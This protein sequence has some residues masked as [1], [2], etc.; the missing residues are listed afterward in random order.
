MKRVFTIA[1]CLLSQQIIKANALPADSTIKAKNVSSTSTRPAD[2]ALALVVKELFPGNSAAPA[3]LTGFASKLN[4]IQKEVQL[5]Y[6]EY[7]QSY[8]DIYTRHKDEMSHVLGLSKYYFPIYEKVFREAGIP[9]EIKYLSIVESKLDPF[10]VSR[11]GATGPWQFMPATAKTYGLSMD[12]Y[13][14]ERRDPIQACYAAAAY[15]KDA[16]MEFGDWLLAIAS[17]NCGKSNVERAVAKAGAIDFWSIRQYLPS[18]TRNYVPAFIAMSYVMNYAHEHDIA[19]REGSV[20]GRM[21]TVMVDKFIG[22]GNIANALGMEVKQLALLNPSYKKQIVNGTPENPRRL[23]IPHSFEMDY[24]T[25]Y[26]ALND[27]AANIAVQPKKTAIFAA[28]QPTSISPLAAA[29]LDKDVYVVKRGETLVDVASTYGIDI[30]DLKKW[31]HLHGNSLTPGKKIKLTPDA[32]VSST[33]SA[34]NTKADVILYKV[35]PGDTLSGIADKFDGAT[36]DSIKLLNGLKK[37]GLQPG[38]R[39]KISRG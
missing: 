18:E 14:D 1:L 12:S 13:I 30:A 21:D 37:S 36:V 19:I 27:P 24:A 34:N 22:L 26:T 8:I 23:V 33:V 6:N 11:V 20:M 4:A 29:S 16:Y 17:Y 2:T 25:L 7:V 15:L 3:Q 9:E 31:N 5:D 38:M 28:P 10:A 32:I 35:K 39:L